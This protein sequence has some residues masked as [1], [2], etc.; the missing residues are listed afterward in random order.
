GFLGHK[1]M[2]AQLEAT[3]EG[4][5]AVQ[6]RQISVTMT[7][8]VFLAVFRTWTAQLRDIAIARRAN[9]RVTAAAVPCFGTLA[10][11]DE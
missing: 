8:E 3:Y 11:T 5:E 10:D 1:W 4:P 9:V 6:R 7:S 2:D